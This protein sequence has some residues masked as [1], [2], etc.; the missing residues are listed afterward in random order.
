MNALSV[1]NTY[2]DRN[3]P[4]DGVLVFWPQTYNA[5]AGVWSCG[6]ENLGKMEDTDEAI[7]DYLHKIMD[8]L[9]MEK[10]WQKYLSPLQDFL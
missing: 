5:T 4:E 3:R 6:P 10:A 2:H 7:L 1:V 8:D 9:G